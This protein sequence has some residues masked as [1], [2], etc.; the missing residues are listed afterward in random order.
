MKVTEQDKSKMVQAYRTHREADHSGEALAPPN[1]VTNSGIPPLTQPVS[2][3]DGWVTF[4]QPVLC[5]YAGK[6]PYVGR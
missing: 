2:E 3:E 5:I 4:D 1:S 6:G